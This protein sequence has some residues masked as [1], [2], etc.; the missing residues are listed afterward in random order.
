VLR[1][2]TATALAVALLASCGGPDEP[3]G[4]VTDVT[5]ADDDGLNG[6]VLAEPYRMPA[7]SLTA[8]DGSSYRLV[9]DT[10]RE[11][12]LVFFGYTHCPDVCQVVMADIASAMTRLDPADRE[13]V[14]MLF[15][16]SD[17]ARDDPAA[18]RDYLDRFDPSFEGLTGDLE[19]IVAV[20]NEL[21]VAVEKGNRLPS[22]GYEVAHGTQVVGVDAH[23][24]APVGWTERKSA[25]ELA[26][27]IT[28]IL[29]GGVATAKESSTP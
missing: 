29:D 10:T 7:R 9:R 23:R 6:A 5:V 22:G 8:T 11:L 18:L 17:P 3:Q 12:T 28:A 26:E 15:I 24:P 13:R 16:T 19:R 4:P 20:G 27:D 21:G 25:Q 14:G 2:A 1:A